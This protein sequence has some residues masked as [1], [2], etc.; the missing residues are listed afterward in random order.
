MKTIKNLLGHV[1][2][3]FVHGLIRDKHKMLV[4][5]GPCHCQKCGRVWEL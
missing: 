2:C 4:A 1:W 5:Y 3:F